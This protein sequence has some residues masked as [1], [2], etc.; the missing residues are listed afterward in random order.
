MGENTRKKKILSSFLGIPEKSKTKQNKMFCFPHR[1]KNFHF[2][3]S[4]NI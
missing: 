2:E 3:P 4:L 1:A